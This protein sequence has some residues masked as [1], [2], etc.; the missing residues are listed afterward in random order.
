MNMAIVCKALGKYARARA[1]YEEFISGFEANA[2]DAH[3]VDTLTAK[4]NLAVLCKELDELA[5]ATSLYKEV[6]AG[7]TELYG[8]QHVNTLTA[9][10][11]L[12][13]VLDDL[14]AAE[15]LRS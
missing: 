4:M 10:C 3:H 1:M 11:N 2:G 14:P 9:K 12:A 13:V 6:V 15:A 8:S 5:E 7:Y